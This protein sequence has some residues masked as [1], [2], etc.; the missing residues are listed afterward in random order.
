MQLSSKTLINPAAKHMQEIDVQ[1]GMHLG[2]LLARNTVSAMWL[3]VSLLDTSGMDCVLECG[4]ASMSWHD[5]FAVC[6]AEAQARYN[7]C[8]NSIYQRHHTCHFQKGM[9]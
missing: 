3:S 4:S 5:S 9:V 2:C 1:V 6:N 7:E 8:I